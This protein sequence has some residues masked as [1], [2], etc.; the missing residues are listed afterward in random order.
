MTQTRRMT[1]NSSARGAPVDYGRQ[2]QG[3][4]C[5]PGALG[6]DNLHRLAALPRVPDDIRGAAEPCGRSAIP[7]SEEQVRTIRYG[8]ARCHESLFRR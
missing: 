8:A 2:L 1:P 7:H 5:A 4:L 3:Q 6:P